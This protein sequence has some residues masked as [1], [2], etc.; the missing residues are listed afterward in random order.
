MSVKMDSKSS[1]KVERMDAEPEAPEL[2]DMEAH[3][4]KVSAAILSFREEGK[5]VQEE[6]ITLKDQ[7]NQWFAAG[8]ARQESDSINLYVLVC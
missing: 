2:F 5:A 8:F 7:I 6:L 4:A 3:D 1:L